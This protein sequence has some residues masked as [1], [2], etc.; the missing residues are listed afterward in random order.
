MISDKNLNTLLNKYNIT[1]H[2]LKDSLNLN[3]FWQNQNKK[4]MFNQSKEQIKVL[5]IETNNILEDIKKTKFENITESNLND[6][7][8]PHFFYNTNKTAVVL[9]TRKIKKGNWL[10]IN[11]DYF[12]GKKNKNSVKWTT[13]EKNCLELSCSIYNTPY[14]SYQLFTATQGV[15]SFIN[16]RSYIKFT[17]KRKVINPKKNCN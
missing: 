5:S 17:N 1:L 8:L 6:I 14:E 9:Q 7:F 3:L 12:I 2:R 4:E 10:E 16:D 13:Y 11:R 15:L